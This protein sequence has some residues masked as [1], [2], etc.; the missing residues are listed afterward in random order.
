MNKELERLSRDVLKRVKNAPNEAHA[1]AQRLLALVRDT[2]DPLSLAVANA[3]IARTYIALGE[4]TA[5]I[6]SFW[7]SYALSEQFAHTSGCIEALNGLGEIAFRLGD[8]DDALERF[9]Q[10]LSLATSVQN[11]GAEVNFKINIAMLHEKLEH[12]EEARQFYEE[13]LSLARKL[14]DNYRIA[15]I[16]NGLSRQYLQLAVAAKARGDQSATDRCFNAAEKSLHFA[17]KTARAEQD[18]E[19]YASAYYNAGEVLRRRG[20]LEAAFSWLEELVKKAQKRSPPDLE[21]AARGLIALADIALEQHK[22]QAAMQQL[23]QALPLL[24][25]EHTL[26]EELV[27]CHQLRSFA[28]DAIANQALEQTVVLSAA[29]IAQSITRLHEALE[30]RTKALEAFKHYTTAEKELRSVEAQRAAANFKTRLDLERI[31]REM[32]LLRL[33]STQLERDNQ[34]LDE[35][36]RLDGLTKIPNRRTFDFHLER[37]VADSLRHSR[38]LA[39]ALF[40]GDRF[41]LVNDTYGHGVGDEVLRQLARIATATVRQ[42][43]FVAR[44]G[45]EE[46]CVVF[47]N[48]PLEQATEICERLR[49]AIETAS[50]AAIAPEL[51]VTASFGVAQYTSSAQALID[52]AD[53][54]LYKAKNSGRNRVEV[55]RVQ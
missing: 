13:S 9:G 1:T 41:K 10:G 17:W 44:Y 39:V 53:D 33:H 7:E 11:T 6:S 3:R 55:A 5:A 21:C 51:G 35:M 24:S 25:G 37:C 19:L 50:W 46:F 29:E 14:K 43:D 28:H 49:V 40:D 48:T 2:N 18:W 16:E 42:G 34:Q 23:D 32:E 30:H 8:F 27:R 31:R 54:A 12:H 45:G 4:Y 38:P 36:A 26:L 20:K 15:I 47:P 52:S 22:P